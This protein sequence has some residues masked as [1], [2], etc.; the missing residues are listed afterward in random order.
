MA[1]PLVVQAAK[2]FLVDLVGGVL[3][4]PVWWYSRGA[5]RWSHFMWDWYA[6]YRATLAVDVWVKNLFVPMYGSYDIAGRLI[7]FF[8]RLVM[9]FLRSFLLLIVS[10]FL[11][12]VYTIYYILPPVVVAALLYHGLGLFA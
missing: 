6:S 9:I 4:F 12:I 3:G 1:Q 11:M 10:I 8:M 7:S 5:V 2:L